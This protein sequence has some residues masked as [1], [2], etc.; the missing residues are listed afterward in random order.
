MNIENSVKD[1]ITSKLEEGIIEKLVAENLEKGINNA[2][3]NLLGRYGDVTEVIEKKIKEVM[4]DQLSGYDYSEYIVKLDYVLGE[5]L[6]NTAL[7]NKKILEN[8][9]RFMTDTEIPKVVKVSDIF[10]EYCDYVAKNVDTSDLEVNTDD[11]PCYECVNVSY[12]VTEHEKKSWSSYSEVSIFFECE[13]D[14]DM[15]FELKLKR[16]KTEKPWKIDIDEKCELASLRHLDEFKMYF[17]KLTQNYTDIEIDKLHDGD[18]VEPEEKPEAE[19][20]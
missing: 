19:F 1:V 14:E 17:L 20:R 16:W 18:E 9:K 11:E 12:E 3:E 8:F 7:D 2:L 6:K 10:R 5:I 4:I 15:N 13:E